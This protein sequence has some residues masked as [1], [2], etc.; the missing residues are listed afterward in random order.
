M[1]EA[2]RDPIANPLHNQEPL[3]SRHMK[4]RDNRRVA[5]IVAALLIA[6]TIT[7]SGCGGGSSPDSAAT[8]ATTSSSSPSS[9]GNASSQFLKPGEKNATVEFGKEAPATMREEVSRLVS[10][11]LKAREAAAFQT[12]CETLSLKAVHAVP[13]GNN[14]KVCPAA[15]KKLA[16][17]LSKSEK[18]RKDTLAGP[19][20]A[21]RVEGN[22]AYALWHGSDGKDYSLRLEKEGGSWR[23]ASILTTDLELTA[24]PAAK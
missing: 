12:Q 14:R 5:G 8:A 23:V 20:A 10:K 9:S 19:I 21:L 6:I 1:F 13:G 24:V 2:L 18:A 11:S 7:A 17:P 16:T 15:L 3:Y 22:E 4:T